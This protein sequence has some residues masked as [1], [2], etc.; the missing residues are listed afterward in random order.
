MVLNKNKL[1]PLLLLVLLLVVYVI[2]HF[3]N[4]HDIIVYIIQ[5]GAEAGLVGGL[6][7][8]F[9]VTAL[10]RKPLGLPIPHTNL[11]ENNRFK[12]IN[13]I[14]NAVSNNW[15]SKRFLKG[16]IEGLDFMDLF[17]N[18]Y[19]NKIISGGG[20]EAEE[21]EIN[22]KVSRKGK[23]DLQSLSRKYLIVLIKYTGSVKF[24]DWLREKIYKII[25][26][27]GNLLKTLRE[28]LR[29]FVESGSFDDVYNRIYKD[30]IK[31]YVSSID[32]EKVSG[33]ANDLIKK[34]LLNSRIF[35]DF[36]TSI[37]K[38]NFAEAAEYAGNLA[39]A[40]IKKNNRKIKLRIKDEINLF[41][42]ENYKKQGMFKS[43]LVSILE[44][45]NVIDVNAISGSLVRAL[46]ERVGNFIREVRDNPDGKT[47]SEY[48]DYILDF[49]INDL[50]KSSS[51]KEKTMFEAKKI[52]IS[53]LETAKD[54]IGIYLESEG[55]V[56]R[57]RNIALDFLGGENDNANRL[58][59]YYDEK[60]K[61]K[62]SNLAVDLSN[63]FIKKNRHYVL[64]REKFS[65]K[66][67]DVAGKLKAFILNHRDKANR[68]LK[69]TIINVMLL[70]H[71]KIKGLV[72]KNLESL[73]TRKLVEQIE[74]KV[75]NDLQYIRINGS[76]MGFIIGVFI[77]AINI[78]V[79]GL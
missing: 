5:G 23:R 16:Q 14:G 71:G 60:F 13:T 39:Q 79:H 61:I 51:I 15:L 41:I 1:Y 38:E 34:E 30:F 12:I 56:S 53:L 35:K 21:N 28:K 17:E 29:G 19:E 33:E 67:D 18:Y 4:R 66:F 26:K 9:A 27:D 36:L 63:D 70:S 3:F 7:D 74:S 49:I 32:I 76:V 2:T 22:K 43:T 54:K 10:F 55:A 6:A 50:F 31:G 52:I 40:F 75:G 78:I 8:W 58:F 77:A 59:E 45:T 47:A 11:I 69:D 65:V 64:N 48:K 37:I 20:R 72:T 57:I 68:M 44:T 62:I 46:E 24:K 42:E 25:A 73:E